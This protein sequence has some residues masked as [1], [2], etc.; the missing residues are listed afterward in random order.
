MF[1]LISEIDGRFHGL[2]SD[3]A[4]SGRVLIVQNGS[5]KITGVTKNDEG[6][7]ECQVSNEV[8]SPLKKSAVL[9]VIGEPFQ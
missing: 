9:K 4:A 1:F 3:V 6:V 5:L 2:G 7:Y 8:G